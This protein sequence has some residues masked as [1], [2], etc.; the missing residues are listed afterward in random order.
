MNNRTCIKLAIILKKLNTG[1]IITNSEA[2]FLL[3][4]GY[5]EFIE[6]VFIDLAK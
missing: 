3:N 4:Q 6:E 1:K 2:M 5:G